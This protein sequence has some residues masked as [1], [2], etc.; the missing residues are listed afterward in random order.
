MRATIVTTIYPPD[1]G[2]PATYAWEVSRRLRERGHQVTV[3]TSSR[4]ARPAPGVFVPPRG[5]PNTALL[6]AGGSYSLV[7]LDLLR[8]GARSDVFLVQNPLYL[9]LLTLLAG[10][11][12]GKPVVLRFPGDKAWEYAHGSGQTSKTMHDFL[13]APEG[14]SSVRRILR[15]QRFV[16]RRADRVIAPSRYIKDTIVSCYGLPSDRVSVIYQS[17]DLADFSGPNHVQLADFS[18]PIVLSVGRLVRHKR[19]DGLIRAM[20]ALAERY[21]G[22]NLLI[23]GEG[24]EEP[25][26]RHLAN[27]LGLSGRVHFLGSV[28]RHRVIGLLRKADVFVLNSLWEGQPHVAVEAMA[29]G[30]PVVATAIR[31]MDE[32][33]I[34]GENGFLVPLDADL[35][36]TIARVL[37]SGQLRPQFAEN[38]ARRGRQLFC[39]QHNLSLLEHELASSASHQAHAIAT[40]AEVN[41]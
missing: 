35:S 2:G 1:I 21:P 12:L 38:G 15:I 16:V 41:Q 34:D 29:A 14:N 37:D 32:V 30:A 20:P 6:G 17:V 11:I 40:P 8:A 27:S 26:L 13:A 33:V 4:K 10:R 36:Q 3:V 5:L 31:G 19:V 18:R 24:P 22:A 23:A 39:W 25:G 28:P 9:G 7:L